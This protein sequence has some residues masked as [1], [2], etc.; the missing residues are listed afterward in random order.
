MT[1][2]HGRLLVLGVDPFAEVRCTGFT[3]GDCLWN[4][5][6][7]QR[8]GDGKIDVSSEQSC[9]YVIYYM[10]SSGSFVVA[11]LQVITK[12]VLDPRLSW[13]DTC[14]PRVSTT[15]RPGSRIEDGE[16]AAAP[17]S[18]TDSTE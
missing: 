7:L 15:R 17:R 5:S 13:E 1:S 16:G 9:V 6:L 3:D 10:L 11:C 4:L 12:G 14:A 8:T 2:T 18:T